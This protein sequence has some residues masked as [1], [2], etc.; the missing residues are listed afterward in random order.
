MLPRFI[1]R[2]SSLIVGIVLCGW[3]AT[4][5]ASSIVGGGIDLGHACLDGTTACAGTPS[6]QDF[7]LVGLAAATG[8]V[9]ITPTGNVWPAMP[10]HLVDLDVDV[11]TLV[12]EDTSVAV[13]GVDKILFTNLT[14]DVSGVP[15]ADPGT[16]NLFLTGATLVTVTGTYEQFLG[17]TSVVGP[18]NFSQQVSLTSLACPADGSGN[19][20]FG[21]QSTGAMPLNLN[22][23]TTGGGTAHDFGFTFNVA[24][25]EPSTAALL[26]LGLIGLVGV[27]RRRN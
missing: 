12:M 4:A 20:G 15:T 22:V 3:V 8:T 7:T 13:D 11:T 5:N 2:S 1:K 24:I 18:I 19:C 17:A 10:T 26:G 21:L 6:A 16:G 27:G 25:P 23:G 9:T 14:F